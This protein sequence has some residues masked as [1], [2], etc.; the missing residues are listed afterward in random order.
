[1]R[2]SRSRELSTPIG[3]SVTRTS[4][5]WLASV[6]EPSAIA[7][8][9]GW[10]NC[11]APACGFRSGQVTAPRGYTRRLPVAHFTA[12]LLAN[13]T[14]RPTIHNPVSVKLGEV[15]PPTP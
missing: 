3:H 15:A 7:S 1:M 14:R 4:V 10:E 6:E 2:L 5:R 12:D 8:N 9:A 13:L 11:V